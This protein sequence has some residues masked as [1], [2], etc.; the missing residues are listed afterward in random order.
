M[1]NDQSKSPGTGADI[2]S[3]LL[4]IIGAPASQADITTQLTTARKEL[5][6]LGLRNALL[7]YRLLKA[8][9]VDVVDELPEQIFKIMVVDGKTMSFLP[10]PD[11]V[12]NSEGLAQIEE[13]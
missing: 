8:R 12:D 4:K 5:L 13:E 2:S 9:G 7:N 11:K 10:A 6:D 3:E 1:D